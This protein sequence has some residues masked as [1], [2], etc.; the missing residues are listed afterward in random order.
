ML[1]IPPSDA[2]QLGDCQPVY[3]ELPGW[4]RPTHEAKRFADLPKAAR[5]YL[6]TIA[7]LTGAA[8]AIASVGPNRDQ[9]I[10]L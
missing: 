9:T 4:L 10:A 3:I 6:R 5:S 2:R 8:L 7:K 1:K